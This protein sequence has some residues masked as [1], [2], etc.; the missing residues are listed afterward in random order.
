MFED[1]DDALQGD[2]NEYLKERGFDEEL[3]DF[4]TEYVQFKEQKEYKNWL[5]SVASFVKA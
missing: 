3:A 4:I 5:E 2:F 1:L